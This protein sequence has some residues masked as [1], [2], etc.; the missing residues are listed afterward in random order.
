MTIRAVKMIGK[1]I[2]DFVVSLIISAIAV[3]I[4]AT[5]ASVVLWIASLFV[6][7]ITFFSAFSSKGRDNLAKQ[8]QL[9]PFF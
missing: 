2:A 5:I 3:P 1:T 4:G 6:I 7:L 9:I 8:F